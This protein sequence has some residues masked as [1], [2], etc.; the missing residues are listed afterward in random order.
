M[1]ESSAVGVQVCASEQQLNLAEDPTGHVLGRKSCMS[2]IASIRRDSHRGLLTLMTLLGCGGN[3]L[4]GPNADA[5]VDGSSLEDAGCAFC[6]TDSASSDDWYPC[7]PNPANY[8]IPG[9]GCDD[10]GDG[11]VDNPP[12][13]CDT[14]VP[15]TAPSAAQ[16]AQAIGICPDKGASWG[17]LSATYTQGV[18]STE[19]PMQQQYG[20]SSTFGSNVKARQGAA[21]GILSTGV[22]AAYDCGIPGTFKNNACSNSG[23]GSPPPGWVRGS[24]FRAT[25][26]AARRSTPGVEQPDG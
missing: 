17:V 11:I 20:T 13:L 7:F 21:L 14:G 16:F 23:V 10:D 3:Q 24:T 1:R 6:S 8:D 12:G 2:P 18:G 22:A 9:N 26:R 4:T 25:A 5:A 19:A 15:V